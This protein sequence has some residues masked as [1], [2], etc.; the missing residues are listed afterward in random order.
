MNVWALVGLV[1]SLTVITVMLVCA[2]MVSSDLDQK[3]QGR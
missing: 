3:G 1:V 2:V